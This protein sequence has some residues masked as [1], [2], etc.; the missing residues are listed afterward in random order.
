M[1][2]KKTPLFLC[3]E[4]LHARMVS[5]GGWLMPVQ[6]S[7]VIEEHI[8]TRTHVG[9]FDISHMGELLIEGKDAL[10]F[11][12]KMVTQD[13]SKIEVGHQARYSLLC[14]ESGGVVD[15][16]LI[17]VLNPTQVFLCVNA[18]NIEQDDE[19]LKKHHSTEN[20]TIRNVSQAYVQIALQGPK[21]HLLL[22]TFTD[23]DLSKLTYYHYTFGSI[24]DIHTLISR[25]GYT[26][27]DGFELYIPSEKGEFLWQALLERGKAYQILPCGL[28]ARDTLRLEMGFPLYGHEMDQH[29]TA[30]EANL[31]W[32][33]ALAKTENFIGKEALSSQKK[34]G[35]KKKLIGFEM[36]DPQIPRQS[37]PIYNLQKELI[38]TV[39]SGTLSPTLKKGIG[40]GHITLDQHSTPSEVLIGIRHH[41]A[42][43]KIVKPPFIQKKR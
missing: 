35:V 3:H 8:N 43:A 40:M 19:W 23:S 41:D 18:A 29:I 17:Y 36:L 13:V 15:D 10:A 4:K 7:S 14:N 9:L 38:G 25:T 30:L 42:K 33:V 24:L 21:A 34:T 5:F 2:L 28:G 20:I 26:G 32:V 27:E 22:Q 39:S 37:Y 31:G 16:I 12:Q 1:N 11:T 6:Y